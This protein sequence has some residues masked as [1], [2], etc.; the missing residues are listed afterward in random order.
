M[1]A[2]VSTPVSAGK[3]KSMANLVHDGQIIPLC[4]FYLAWITTQ[5]EMCLFFSSRLFLLS[6][7]VAGRA[8]HGKQKTD[9]R[10][11]TR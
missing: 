6:G 1:R 8:G 2:P 9:Q 10:I 5:R 4:G 11:K 3:R 7:E